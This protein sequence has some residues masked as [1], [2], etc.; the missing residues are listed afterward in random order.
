MRTIALVAVLGLVGLIAAACGDDD[1]SG[2]TDM[3]MGG[4]T[5]SAASASSLTVNLKN[6]AIQSSSKTLAA[7]KVTFTATHAAEHGA[8]NMDGQEG[9]THQLLVAPLPQG[10]KAGQGKF[11]KPVL[12]LTDIKPG[13]TKTGEAELAPGTYEVACLVVEQVK[14]KTVDH[15]E[16]G[17]YALVTVK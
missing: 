16:K 11:G 10:A 7:G 12:N 9:A 13:E 14:G 17:M 15:Y 8:M 6:W 5:G 3:D 4:G 1:T 2:K